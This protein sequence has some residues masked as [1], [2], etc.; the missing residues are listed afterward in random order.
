MDTQ[1]RVKELEEQ[2]RYHSDLYFNKAAPEIT[3]AEFDGLV[4]EL[5]LLSPESAVLGEVGSVPSYGQKVKHSSLM[6]SLDKTKESTEIEA[7][8]RTYTRDT[9]HVP[10]VVISPKMDGLAVR[11]VYRDGR[12]VEA[13]T[14]GNGCV[15]GETQLE[16]EGG[17]MI[18][19]QEIV[20][21]G[22]KCRVKC[23]DVPMGK[24]CF[25]D[26]SAVFDNGQ[27]K[28]WIEL[29]VKDEK[30]VRHKL[31]LT[32]DHQ[33]LSLDGGSPHF[34]R[35]ENLKEGEDVFGT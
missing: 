35:A 14:R 22:L 7:W 10:K 16:D 30:G 1:N 20:S 32:P 8:A 9:S 4:N 18:S 33:V 19:I 34:V 28:D 24:I 27:T 29:T 26:V 6:G 12:L 5:R 2:I 25:G 15:D 13:A 3:D 21:S 17:K 31:I 11:L 23:L